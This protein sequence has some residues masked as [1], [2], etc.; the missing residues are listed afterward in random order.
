MQTN[1][2]ADIKSPAEE[3]EMFAPLHTYTYTYIFTLLTYL[4]AHYLFV[5]PLIN[6]SRSVSSANK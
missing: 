2:S 5:C 3:E 4:Q 6:Y 1:L